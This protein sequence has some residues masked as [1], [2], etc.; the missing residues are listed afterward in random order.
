MFLHFDSTSVVNARD[1]VRLG[2]LRPIITPYRS[3][4]CT[5]FGFRF[6]SSG[7]L[8]TIY[9]HKVDRVY[10]NRRNRKGR[11]EKKMIGNDSKR[12]LFWSVHWFAIPCVLAMWS[13]TAQA[14]TWLGFTMEKKPGGVE[15]L[16]VLDGSPARKAGMKKGDL[17]FRAEG[18]R[19]TDP[20]D[21]L[22][23]YAKKRVGDTVTLVLARKGKERKV[24]L[25]LTKQPPLEQMLRLLLR[26]ERARS[27][28]A[29]GVDGATVT[30]DSLKGNVVLLEFW[31]TWCTSCVTSLNK[32]KNIYPRLRPKGFRIVALARNT[33][34]ETRKKAA[35]LNLP[36]IVAADPGAKIAGSYHLSKV[37][38]LVLIDKKGIIRDIRLGSSYQTAEIMKAAER[39][40]K[41]DP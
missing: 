41:E 25:R 35:S 38:S 26:G 11:R 10:L 21:I 7:F 14:R 2:T 28:K 22:K 13:T 5:P 32:L 9:L 4:V 19:V 3:F 6:H 12:N 33:L 39:L 27:F 34:A 16:K 1:F 30:L 23:S 17:V 8:N 40:L 31:A 29:T 36:F 24:V 18:N 15:V 20:S 37:P